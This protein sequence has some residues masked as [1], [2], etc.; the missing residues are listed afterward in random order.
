MAN[1]DLKAKLVLQ[2]SATG[3]SEIEALA[4]HLQDLAREGGDAAPFWGGRDRRGLHVG[5]ANLAH[6]ERPVTDGETFPPFP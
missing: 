3:G 2:A 4:Q 6:P 5:G 1:E